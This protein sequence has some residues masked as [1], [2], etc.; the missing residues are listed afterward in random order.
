MCVCVHM[1]EGVRV[2]PTENQRS[3]RASVAALSTFD[4]ILK[5]V[6]KRG[7]GRMCLPF[8]RFKKIAV[9]SVYGKAKLDKPQHKHLLSKAVMSLYF[10]FV[11][12]NL[13]IQNRHF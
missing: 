6:G 13:A 7:R 9:M 5:Q 10:I 12:L 8:H 4:Y 11:F 3:D 1:C 2:Q